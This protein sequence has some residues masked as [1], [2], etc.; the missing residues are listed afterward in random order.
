LTS[1]YDLFGWLFAI[2]LLKIIFFGSPCS[3][4]FVFIIFFL[5]F[6]DVVDW[7][8]DS[9]PILIFLP[10]FEF[11]AE[12]F[13]WLSD[14]IDDELLFLLNGIMLFAVLKYWGELFEFEIIEI[15]FILFGLFGWKLLFAFDIV[16]FAL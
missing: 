2:C 9:E 4:E 1:L 16:V 10:D 7:Y 6:F 11:I 3:N 12:K 13:C 5:Y 15:I 14:S 8:R